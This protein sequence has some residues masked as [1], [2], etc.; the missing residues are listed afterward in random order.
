MLK[1]IRYNIANLTNFEGRDARQTFWYWVLAVVV[2]QYAIAIIA[3]VPMYVAMF[4]AI[5]SA[6]SDNPQNIDATAMMMDGMLEDMVHWIKIQ[7]VISSIVGVISAA[8]LAASFVRR[9][10]DGGFSG[11]LAVIPFAA[12]FFSLAYNIV[13]FDQ[14]E[15]MMRDA[16]VASFEAQGANPLAMQAEMGLSGLIGWIAPIIGIIFGAWP[17]TDGPNKYGE[18]SVSF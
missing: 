5:F 9:L 11:W 13:F 18:T 1:S 14:M 15:D 4:S 12:Y 8:L 16:M 6:I 17:S 3:S 2:V 10:H 7:I